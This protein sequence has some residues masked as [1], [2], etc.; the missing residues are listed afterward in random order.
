M[1]HQLLILLVLVII[2]AVATVAV[3]LNLVG[4][5]EREERLKRRLTAATTSTSAPI[6]TVD[7][8]LRLVRQVSRADQIKEKA[9][10]LIGV[11]LQQAETYPIKWWLVPPIA[12]VITLVI[13][14]LASHP[15]GK[16][17]SIWL[18]VKYVGTPVF[19]YLIDRFI[20]NWLKNRRN[21]KLIEQF[22]DALNIIVRCVRVGIPIGEALRTVAQDSMEPT[23]REFTI[24]ADK[25]SI[26]IPLDVSLREL[27][28]RVKLT[29]YQFFAT[30]ITLQAR[31]GG[32]ITQTLETLADVIRK[33]VAL[34]SRGYA[35]TA[36]ARMG[37]MVLTVLPFL[38]GAGLFWLQPNYIRI[39]FTTDGGEAILGAAILLLAAGMGVIQFMISNVLK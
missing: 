33:R 29:E 25:V 31:S 18:L 22:P 16:Y 11:D 6:T 24:L 3:T 27:S 15:L 14:W 9:A 36:E 12:A 30:A 37:S 2:L 17:P 7:E 38:A 32:G 1:L 5:H 21:A 20:F 10:E 26:G 23:K 39:L 19:W 34:K 35:L 4:A 8:E 13:I 28:E